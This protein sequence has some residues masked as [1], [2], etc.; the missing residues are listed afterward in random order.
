MVSTVD[1]DAY[2]D[3]AA[4]NGRLVTTVIVTSYV[5]SHPKTD[6]LLQVVESLK[7]IP[8][9]EIGPKIIVFDGYNVSMDPKIWKTKK[10]LLTVEQAE[11][12]EMYFAAVK[13]LYEGD[14]SVRDKIRLIKLDKHMGFAFAVREALLMCTTP[15]AMIVQHDRMFTKPF[16]D[17]KKVVKVMETNGHIKYVGLPTSR[18]QTHH[19]KLKRKYKLEEFSIKNRINVVSEERS[20]NGEAGGLTTRNLYLQPCIFWY[21]SNHLCNVNRYLKIYSPYLQLFD[22]S[23]IEYC[24]N[25]N[26]KRTKLKL[27]DFIED[28]FGQAQRT[29]LSKLHKQQN[30]TMY[31]KLFQTFGSYLL[32]DVMYSTTR[33]LGDDRNDCEKPYAGLDLPQVYVQHLRGRQYARDSK[34]ALNKVILGK[35]DMIRT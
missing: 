2:I 22:K 20:E 31:S 32:F 10:G 9:L 8:S 29:I 5:R 7:C 12:Y 17:F 4:T 6:L 18:S 14:T 3:T 1:V 25:E 13:Q 15:Y 16:C 27:G 19:V 21:D 11:R 24:G 35:S 26:I 28:K 34:N 33:L 23:V 30:E